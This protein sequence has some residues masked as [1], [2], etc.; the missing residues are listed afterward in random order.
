MTTMPLFVVAY[1]IT[2]LSTVVVLSFLGVGRIEIYL[3][4]LTL[5]FLAIS[6][7]NLMPLTRSESQR[8]NVIGILLLAIFAGIVI[9]RLIQI[10][11]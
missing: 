2:A 6:E 10:L 1:G 11:P 5:E 4:F 8:K 9:V 7:F 3:A